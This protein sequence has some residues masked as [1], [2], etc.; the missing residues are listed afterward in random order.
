MSQKLPLDP[1]VWVFLLRFDRDLAETARSAGCSCGGRLHVANY[2]RKFRGDK[3]CDD[4]A[5]GLRF[6]F[7]CEIE[8]CRQRTTPPSTR[9]L[10]R[11]VYLGAIVVL[12]SALRQGPTPWR[13]AD[14]RRH[15]GVDLRTIQRWQAWFREE[16]PVSRCGRVV[17][18]RCVGLVG[19][20]PRALL[21]RLEES[22]TEDPLVVV[23]CRFA[24][25]SIAPRSTDLV[26]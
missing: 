21:D 26:A 20:L 18:M 19:E 7:C 10:E 3:G 23:M 4:P 22:G 11:R 15:L 1:R 13:M 8:G 2:P 6:S 12:V 9:F 24:E 25:F 5:F 17:R 14:L 16:F